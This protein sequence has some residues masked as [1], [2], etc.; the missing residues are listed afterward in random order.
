MEK[1]ILVDELWG[2]PRAFPKI[3]L[4]HVMLNINK[5]INSW[6]KFFLFLMGVD[7]IQYT[8]ISPAFS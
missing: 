5:K 2:S 8:I 4:E 3:W 7:L 1:I 6:A